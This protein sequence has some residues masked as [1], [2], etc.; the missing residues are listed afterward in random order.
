MWKYAYATKIGTSHLNNNT[1]CQDTSMCSNFF[2]LD[3]N[4]I[5]LAVI[6]DGAGSALYGDISSQCVCYSFIKYVKNKLKY[7][8]LNDFTNVDYQEFITQ[9]TKET[10][11]LAQK[12]NTPLSN[13]N[14][15]FLGF[16]SD[17][18]I[19]IFFQV[20]DGAIVTQIN[21]EWKTVFLPDKGEFANTTNFIT[22]YDRHKSFH[23]KKID[24]TPDFIVLFSDGIEHLVLK[25]GDQPHDQFFNNIIKPIQASKIS[26]NN[27]QLSLFLE[28]HLAEPLFCEKTDDDKSLIIIQYLDN[29]YG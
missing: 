20:G 18:N 6:S 22:N 1:V 26:G 10:S 14:C 11:E 2:D 29:N 7:K 4:S 9:Y 8:N 28:K 3:K 24:D 13:F 25:N 17:G 12:R 27:K 15:T 19:S 23:F 21:K 5:M 16:V